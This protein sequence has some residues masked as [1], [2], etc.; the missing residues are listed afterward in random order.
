MLAK[1]SF[2]STYWNPRRLNI[3]P[4]P[5]PYT[6]LKEFTRTTQN[7]M[8]TSLVLG[9]ANKAVEHPSSLNHSR[10][11]CDNCSLRNAIEAFLDLPE[12]GLNINRRNL[13]L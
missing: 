12:D 5:W 13:R 9:F 2:D 6:F 4:L 8:H 7:R 1:K 11:L 3:N 10:D